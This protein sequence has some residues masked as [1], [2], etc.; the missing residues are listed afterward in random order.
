M[1]RPTEDMI[2][3]VQGRCEMALVRG[4]LL[5]VVRL[6]ERF[7]VEP[8]SRNAWEAL[9]I[10]SEYNGRRFCLQVDDMAGKQEVVIKSLGPTLQGIPGVAG[11]GDP[12]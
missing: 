7:H 1:L 8:R 6:H 3:T 2:S 12:G 5:P 9:L 4:S 10:V 11:G